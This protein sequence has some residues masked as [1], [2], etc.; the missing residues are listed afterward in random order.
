MIAFYKLILFISIIILILLL[1]FIGITMYYFPNTSNVYPQYISDCPDY[2]VKNED[3]TCSTT[4]GS[5]NA[6]SSSY[7]ESK[8]K[9][10]HNI[11][12]IPPCD[13]EKKINPNYL[14]YKFDFS[15]NTQCQNKRW[16]QTNGIFWDGVSNIKNNH[17]C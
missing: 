13:L 11:I 5:V 9:Q 16:A 7:N 1:A 2:W 6:I 12:V 17:F 8:D 15:K 14:T 10:K 3:G 4:I